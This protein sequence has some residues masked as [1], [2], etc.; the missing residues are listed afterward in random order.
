[1]TSLQILLVE[2]DPSLREEV[3]PLMLEHLLPSWSVKIAKARDVP[4]ARAVLGV[5][6]DLVLIDRRLPGLEDGLDLIREL[7]A[8]ARARKIL[9]MSG[10]ADDVLSAGIEAGADIA[11]RKP[12]DMARLKLALA[13]LGFAR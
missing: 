5:D 4:G 12:F 8:S 9:F 3:F 7:R 11:I 1:M 6:Y 13:Q 2:D 10:S